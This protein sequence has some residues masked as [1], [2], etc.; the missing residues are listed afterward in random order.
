[1]LR[2]ECYSGHRGEQ[3][4]RLLHIINERQVVIE[5]VLDAWLAPDRR[6]FKMKGGDGR[7]RDPT[8]HRERQLG[9]Y[10]WKRATI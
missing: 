8:R 7:L 4:P 3:T 5:E 1:M 2:V 6:Y 10:M 9:T